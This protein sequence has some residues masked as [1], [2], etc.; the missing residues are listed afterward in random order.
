MILNGSQ[1]NVY[2]TDTFDSVVMRIAA[3]FK[4]LPKFLKFTPLVKD[5]TDFTG[6][7]LVINYLPS[8]INNTRPEM[9][10]V[11]LK[12]DYPQLDLETIQKIFIATNNSLEDIPDNLIKAVF[13]S[14]K[15]NFIV[16]INDVWNKRR[17]IIYD[18]NQEI[19][20]NKNV[21]DEFLQLAQEFNN[22]SIVPF[23]KF[24]VEKI[25]FS[26]NYGTPVK[27][28]QEIFNAL[29]C[30]NIIPFIT[31]NGIY[32][33]KKDFIPSSK[34]LESYAKDV[35]ALKTSNEKFEVKTRDLY[36]KFNTVILGIING[37]LIA[38]VTLRVNDQTLNREEFITSFHENLKQLN[39]V[40]LQDEE[41][42]VTGIYTYPNQTIDLSVWSELAMNDPIFNKVIVIDESVRASKIKQNAYVHLINTN[43]T[44]SLQMKIAEKGLPHLTEGSAYIR[45]R[46]PKTKTL[47]EVSIIQVLLGK[48]FAAYNDKYDQVVTGYKKY[49]PTFSPVA[50]KYVIKRSKRKLTVRDIAP[51]IFFPRFSRICPSVPTIITPEQ[52]DGT[53]KVMKYPKPNNA[54]VVERLYV[55]KT[56]ARPFPGLRENTNDNFLK[57]P[58]IPCCFARDQSIEYQK[59]SKYR[60]YFFDEPLKQKLSQSQFLTGKIVPPQVLGLLPNNIETLFSSIVTPEYKFMRR[61]VNR[62]NTSFIEAV[63][64]AKGTLNGLEK[65][66]TEILNT[67]RA[68][69]FTNNYASVIKQELWDFSISDA[70]LS[71]KNDDLRATRFIRAIEE[72]YNVTVYIFSPDKAGTML[73]PR[74]NK[75]YYKL[76]PI[77]EVVLIYQHWGSESNVVTYPQ[78]ELIVKVE[79]EN[80]RK[81]K[82]SW[83]V[84]DPVSKLV[85]D[86]FKR[87]TRKHVFS[88]IVPEIVVKRFPINSQYIDEYGKTRILN[89][90]NVGNL[91]TL[92][93]DPLPPFA[94]PT[95][96]IITRTLVEPVAK[97]INT[98]NLKPISQNVDIKTGKFKEIVVL[99]GTI[100]GT[101]LIN[102]TVGLDNVPIDYDERYKMFLPTSDESIIVEFSKN[103]KISKHLIQY[104]LFIASEYMFKNNIVQMTDNQLAD[105][106]HRHLTVDANIVYKPDEFS[107]KFTSDISFIRNGVIVVKSMEILKRLLFVIRLFQVR[108]KQILL[109]YKTL[110]NLP[111]FYN[112]LND[113][114]F[115]SNEYLLDGVDA[116]ENLINTKKDE[117]IAYQTIVENIVEP[118]FFKNDLL[119]DKVW[120]AQNTS[121]WQ[122]ANYILHEWLLKGYN[123]GVSNKSSINDDLRIIWDDQSEDE[124]I[125]IK[126]SDAK[127]IWEESDNPSE[128]DEPIKLVKKIKPFV[129]SDINSK[130]NVP[131]QKVAIYKY[132]NEY[133]IV[134]L[135]EITSDDVLLGY[136]IQDKPRY[137][138]LFNI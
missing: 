119:G 72:A 120:L 46:L 39:L 98:Y 44:A 116:V 66:I 87:I 89:I 94:K 6:D 10:S 43:D 115:Y 106:A 117:N 138:V 18:L 2:P 30:T 1:F 136:K 7:V 57:Y 63:L 48:L 82:L 79:R 16:P 73:I 9:E 47:K 59:G 126:K 25:V 22:F 91:L 111:K 27:T 23:T 3:D 19:T 110:K 83:D 13:F 55:C 36:K 109:N 134:K 125:V 33:V 69:L 124:K 121:S 21:A 99:L 5:I 77:N 75:G 8:L 32:K 90:P 12:R 31:L 70:L 14:M 135:N 51:E 96:F 45:V 108:H 114:A 65:N 112:D 42:N 76:K 122:H 29:N 137:T 50:K 49:I 123:V 28:I 95:S 74:H 17:E 58:F 54:G 20:T 128:D 78:C 53:L 71:L 62:T 67:E 34:W 93:T 4:T 24:E 38:L 35:I 68:L 127:K 92:I 101:F 85:H 60:H 11:D 107:P 86:V 132:V 131:Q 26:L 56:K 41:I 103:K 81:Q 37:N 129:K 52:D 133:N 104:A 40:L 105:F 102:D 130:Y 118:Y 97:L 61:G 64:T 88:F 84:D 100:N 113:Y 15:N 80:L